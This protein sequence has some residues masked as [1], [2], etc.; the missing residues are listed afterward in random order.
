MVCV[1]GDS[2]F[3]RMFGLAMTMTMTRLYYSIFQQLSA[4]DQPSKTFL[5]MFLRSTHRGEP[6]GDGMDGGRWRCRCRVDV[7]SVAGGKP[8]ATFRKRAKAL[9]KMTFP[10][11]IS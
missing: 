1:L 11:A 10:F 7:M 2:G 8:L 4:T 9:K 5:K 3:P 6:I